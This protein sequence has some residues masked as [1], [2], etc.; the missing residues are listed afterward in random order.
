MTDDHLR[1]WKDISAFLRTSERT[2]QRW[3]DELGL[4]VH[5]LGQAHRMVSAIPSE[6]RA[7]R[8]STAVRTA[9]R[10]FDELAE[11]PAG[12][13][14]TPPAGVP[15]QA[16]GSPLITRRRAMAVLVAIAVLALGGVAGWTAWRRAAARALQGQDG[17]PLVSLRVANGTAEMVT[18]TV[19]DGDRLDVPGGTDG[20]NICLIPRVHGN[21]LRVD[22]SETPPGE[23][24]KP[25]QFVVRFVLAPGQ[26]GHLPEPSRLAIRWL[27][28]PSLNRVR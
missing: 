16:A 5:R 19:P 18:A 14:T 21:R 28:S 1:G 22:V 13:L 23:T 3:E 8:E 7:W 25:S 9:L 24:P 10:E 15:A 27:A 17:R 6:L 26:E 4:P 11:L 12:S 2:A 20:T